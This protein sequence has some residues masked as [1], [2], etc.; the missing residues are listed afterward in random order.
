MD[1]DQVVQELH[2]SLSTPPPPLS[3]VTLSLDPKPVR[4]V[5]ALRSC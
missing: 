4:D 1:D 3:T 2:V 5:G